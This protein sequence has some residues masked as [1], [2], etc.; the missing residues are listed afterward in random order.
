MHMLRILEAKVFRVMTRQNN[1]D[2]F[3]SSV[4]TLIIEKSLTG[5][6]Y[7]YSKKV[8]MREFPGSSYY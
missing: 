5:R 4:G 1:D 2:A 8:L 7:M 3:E 6:K